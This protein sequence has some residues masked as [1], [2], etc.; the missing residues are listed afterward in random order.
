M[1]ELIEFL[2]RSPNVTNAWATVASTAIALLALIVAL[3]T[4]RA[5][6]KHNRASVMPLPYISCGDYENRISVNI[7]NNGVGPMVISRFVAAKGGEERDNLVDWMP[8]S[9]QDCS[10]KTSP[11]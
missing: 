6:R 5:Q 3:W 10:G 2:S 11:K 7:H 8:P 4:G 9:P 1:D